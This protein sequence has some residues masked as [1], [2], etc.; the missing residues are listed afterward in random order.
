[1]SLEQII[2]KIK[3]Q[4]GRPNLRKVAW[5]VYGLAV[6]ITSFGIFKQVLIISNDSG[7]EAMQLLDGY[8][9]V[10]GL[11]QST[12]TEIYKF[13]ASKNGKKYYPVGCKSANRIKTENRV[14]F[15]SQGEAERAG[16]T[17]S[18]TCQK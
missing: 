3:G 6:I 18:T 5:V 9:D 14:F 12:G 4:T 7:G 15:E 11:G 10:S 13:L 1:M 2:E 8:F 17:P 16:Y